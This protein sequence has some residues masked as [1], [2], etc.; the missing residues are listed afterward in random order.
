MPT[1]IFDL[2]HA[3]KELSAVPVWI[4]RGSDGLE[5]SATLEVGGV[6]VEGLTLRGTAR[7][8]LMDRHVTFQL[9]YRHS[10][11]IGGPVARIEWRPL[12]P[13]NNKGLG[14]KRLQHV[15]Q[16]SSHHHLFDLN[17]RRSE[18]GVLKGDLPIAVPLEGEPKNFR[19][20]LAVVGKKFRINNI[21]IIPLPPWQPRML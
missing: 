15:I 13:H 3:E 20:L 17:W 10:Q 16:T 12:N 1:K 5:V 2:V 11:I 9:E 4:D 21:Q 7:K 6:T 14:P 8:P 19:A 18:E